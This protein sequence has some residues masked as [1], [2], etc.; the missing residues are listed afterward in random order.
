MARF[1]REPAEGRLA[2]A[3]PTMTLC[4]GAVAWAAACLAGAEGLRTPPDD[5]AG[6]S[7]LLTGLAWA[8]AAPILF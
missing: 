7:E 8:A 6:F 4:A 2:A 5:A 1:T 3:A